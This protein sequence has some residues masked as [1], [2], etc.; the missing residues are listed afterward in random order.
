MTIRTTLNDRLL[1]VS[2][3]GVILMAIGV[4]TINP[5]QSII[6]IERIGF[7]DAAFALIITSGAA[8]SVAASVIIGIYT[9]QTGRFREAI[10]GS[11]VIGIL[12]GA[13]MFLVPSKLAF[14]IVH[15]VLF[16]AG[17]TA[18]TQYFAIASVAANENPDLDRAS[19]TA[20]VRAGFSAS[21]ALTPIFWGFALA[22]GA[23]VLNAYA[24][25]AAVNVFAVLIIAQLWRKDMPL[26]M[27]AKS[28]K[29]FVASLSE[30]ADKGLLVRLALI[31]VIS[32]INGLYNIL[33]GL[34]IL[35]NLG[36][37]EADVAIFAGVV[38][39]IEI[40]VM[41]L[42]VRCLKY[43]S[44]SFLIMAGILIYGGFLGVLGFLPSMGF[45][46]WLVVPAGIGAG[47]IL[48]I[49]IGYLQNLLADRAG[50]GS[51]LLSVSHFG[52]TIF[53]S[54]VFAF[55]T[56]FAGYEKV[57]VL[58]AGLAVIASIILYVMDRQKIMQ[59]NGVGQS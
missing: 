59:I 45:A 49:P 8:I 39:F 50:A 2:L 38:A 16:P 22:K 6:G 56:T 21:Y 54:G 15:V 1:Q 47:I 33:L 51:A 27:T 40:P 30:L 10:I 12:G 48:S 23:D 5:F 4:A 58:G 28:G 19:T 46:W 31:C 32:A 44:P 20:F 53:A 29:G 25:V 36:G 17:S 9:D 55:G 13:L 37:A 24:V 11:I 3:T 41:I 18:F 34:L 26:K 14:I 52:G 42:I 35:N 43:V 57:A 7:S